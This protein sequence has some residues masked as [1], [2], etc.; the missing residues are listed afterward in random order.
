MPYSQ[1]SLTRDKPMKENTNGVFLGCRLVMQ[2][3]VELERYAAAADRMA[4]V[5]TKL[6]NAV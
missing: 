4:C 5:H 6:L 3:V 1:Q 2:M